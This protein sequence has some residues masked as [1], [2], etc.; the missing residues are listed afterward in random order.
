M[1]PESYTEK[2]AQAEDPMNFSDWTLHIQPWLGL[3]S[4]RRN[5]FSVWLIDI[6]VLCTLL[7][8]EK[9]HWLS[10]AYCSLPQASICNKVIN[11]VQV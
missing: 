11:I 5:I 3:L 9:Y 4:K 1:L 8:S 2:Q 7:T 6:S 10:A